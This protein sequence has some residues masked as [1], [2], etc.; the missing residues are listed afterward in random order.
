MGPEGNDPLLRRARAERRFCAVWV[1]LN[2]CGGHAQISRF[3]VHMAGWASGSGCQDRTEGM[4]GGGVVLVPADASG[5]GIIR[6]SPL[7]PEPLPGGPRVQVALA[8]W[9]SPTSCPDGVGRQGSHDGTAR[10]APGKGRDSSWSTSLVPGCCAFSLGP[11][12]MSVF[13]PICSLRRKRWVQ[14]CWKISICPNSR[15][16]TG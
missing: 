2:L 5:G 13:L 9:S 6:A 12:L 7:G 4:S 11:L 10:G 14:R 3:C 16:L 15:E 8:L 1:W